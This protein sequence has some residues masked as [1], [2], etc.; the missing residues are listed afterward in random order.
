MGVKQGWRKAAATGQAWFHAPNLLP[1]VLHHVSAGSPP[2]TDGVLLTTLS[3]APHR[4]RTVA[5]GDTAS[6]SG[7]PPYFTIEGRTSVDII[8]SAGYKI[9]ALQV[10]GAGGAG[11]S[12]PGRARLGVGGAVM[13]HC[14]TYFAAV[15]GMLSRTISVPFSP[16]ARRSAP[17]HPAPLLPL[18]PAP[19]TDRER[20]VRAPRR[21]GGGGAGCAG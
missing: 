6:A 10:C 5:A 14:M 3:P 7:S 16:P 20:R 1:C 9:S 19:R 18:R 15:Q 8:K 4:S 13:G 2:P 21:C 17:P 11:R 12:G